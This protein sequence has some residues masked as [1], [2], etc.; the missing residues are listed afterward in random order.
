[1]GK[2][3]TIKAE[4]RRW[5]LP[6]I[7][8]QADL[9]E[10]YGLD[11]LLYCR[12][13]WAIR[14]RFINHETGEEV[15]ARCNR[16]SCLHCGPRKVDLWRQLVKA[17]EP[18]LF[19]TLTKAGQ[20]VEEAA[21]AL[22]TFMQALRRGSKGRGK[23]HVGARPAYPVEYFA[24]MERHSNFEENGFHW[25]LLIKGV[26][27]I[28]YKEVI[29][30]LWRSARHGVAEIGHIERIR[31][32]R[33]IGYVTKYLTKALT[34]GEKG[35][36][37]VE[38]ERRVLAQDEQGHSEY[39]TE[40]VVEQATSKAHRVR[41][42]RQFFP[43]RVAAMRAKLF[44]GMEESME[45]PVEVVEA[46][47]VV[48]NGLPLGQDEEESEEVEEVPVRSPW[49]LVERYEFT[50]D[51][52]EYK[53][54]KRKALLDVLEDVRENRKQLSRRVIHVW[55]YQRSELRSTDWQVA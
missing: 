30:P 7:E 49:H 11:T 27:S 41:Y 22:T 47:S 19:L 48:D 39:V 35:T 34:T 20:T 33:A 5:E 2:A 17:S 21:R 8:Q 12:D 23:G 42:S 9:V 52:K 3:I 16:W 43:E 13:P 4:K 28:P 38:R 44:E 32:P 29:Q 40:V 31:N 14:H 26:D 37:Q 54:R 1:M 53:K 45:Q 6:P 36:R 46:V 15:R 10:D 24:V 18:V 50:N 51:I 25:H 55:A